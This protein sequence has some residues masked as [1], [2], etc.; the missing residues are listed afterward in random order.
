MALLD[1]AGYRL[2]PK[3]F[4]N[5]RDLMD[6]VRATNEWRRRLGTKPPVISPPIASPKPPDLMPKSFPALQCKATASFQT[7]QA[8]IEQITQEP[9]P[10]IL[11]SIK[12]IQGAV[13]RHAKISY[14][15]L[16]SQRRQKIVCE[17]RQIAMALCKLLTSRSFPEIGRLFGGRDH[18]TVLHACRKYQPVIN[19]IA[20]NNGLLLPLADLVAAAFEATGY[21]ILA[22]RFPKSL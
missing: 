21:I 15:D 10:P 18:T 13:C 6:N 22:S 4:T 19:E 7:M 16:I 9:K 3:S 8:P 17:P 11:P 12:Q 14:V 5:V 1:M 20:K 2:N